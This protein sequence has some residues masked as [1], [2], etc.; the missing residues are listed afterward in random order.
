MLQVKIFSWTFSL[1]NSLLLSFHSLLFKHLS[2][3]RYHCVKIAVLFAIE[4]DFKRNATAQ[5]QPFLLN[6]FRFWFRGFSVFFSIHFL[7]TIKHNDNQL[8][9]GYFFIS[10]FKCAN[11]FIESVVHQCSSWLIFYQRPIVHQKNDLNKINSKYR[12]LL[13]N[14][15]HYFNPQNLS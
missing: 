13:R 8:I 14:V 10:F 2:N 1:C 9:W 12:W 5:K 11:K 6:R 15:M 3:I 4:T 7:V